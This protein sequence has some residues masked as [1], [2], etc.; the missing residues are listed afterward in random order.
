MKYAVITGASSGI[1]ECFARKF[2]KMGYSLVLVARRMERLEA[3]SRELTEHYDNITCRAVS[4]DLSSVSECKR[5]M[6]EIEKLKVSFFINNA[7][8]GDC[9][10]FLEGDLNKELEMLDV[11]VKAMHVL[12]KLML[13]KMESQGCGYILNVGSSAGLFPAGPYMATYYATKAY[14]VSFTRAI[15]EE[16]AAHKSPVYI[17]VLCPGPVDTEFNSVANVKFALKG[18]TPAECVDYAITQMKKKKVTIVPTYMLRAGI[19]G[20]RFVPTSILIKMV[21]HQQKKKIYEKK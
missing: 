1:G 19:F 2:A 4:A 20:G 18:I 5:V 9:S 6:K 14:V 3:L 10:F 8:F 13:R 7:G 16:L 15:A 11:N 17:G 12:T 21:G